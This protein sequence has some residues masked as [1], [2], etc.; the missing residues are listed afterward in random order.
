MGPFQAIESK[1]YRL[2]TIIAQGGGN[3]IMRV[4][5]KQQLQLY[6]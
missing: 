5:L 1:N 6:V 2:A 3:A 4:H